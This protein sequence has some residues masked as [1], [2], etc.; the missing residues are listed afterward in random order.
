MLANEYYYIVISTAPQPNT[1]SLLTYTAPHYSISH[2]I[3]GHEN[4]LASIEKA[5]ELGYAPVKINCVM[6]KGVND[7]ELGDFVEWTKDK[8]VDVRF[9]EYMPFDGWCSYRATMMACV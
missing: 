4:V 9:I 8:N 1:P 3:L 5:L 6:M 2:L 7:K